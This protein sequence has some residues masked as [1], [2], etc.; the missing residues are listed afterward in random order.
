MN[1][2]RIEYT[3]RDGYSKTLYIKAANHLAAYMVCQEIFYDMSEDIV[4]I[5]CYLEDEENE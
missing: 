1:Y 2:Y 3:C 4:S 5:E